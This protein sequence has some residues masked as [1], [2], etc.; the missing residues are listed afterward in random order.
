VSSSFSLCGM[1]HAQAQPRT[2]TRKENARP[3]SLLRKKKVGTKVRPTAGA[4]TK[5]QPTS[6]LQK[7]RSTKP[8]PQQGTRV[9]FASVEPS[10]VSSGRAASQLN[11]ASSH[12]ATDRLKQRLA[13]ASSRKSKPRAVAVSGGVSAGFRASASSATTSSSRSLR[14]PTNTRSRFGFATTGSGASSNQRVQ[15]Q[16]SGLPQPGLRRKLR[17]IRPGT[18]VN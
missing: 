8:R 6:R 17:L 9:P 7:S 15:R 14:K 5:I 3:R 10:A 13:A 1:W 2:T 16:R 4:V 11:A 12:P 18:A